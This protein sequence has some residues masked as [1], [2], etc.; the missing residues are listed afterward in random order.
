MNFVELNNLPVYDLYTEFLKLLDEKKIWWH[1]D[2]N[3]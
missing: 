3:D 2:I 1:S